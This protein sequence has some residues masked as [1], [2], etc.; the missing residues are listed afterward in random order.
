MKFTWPESSCAELRGVDRETAVRILHGLTRCGETEVA[1][2]HR[3]FLANR[4]WGICPPLIRSAGP[5]FVP[6]DAHLNMFVG[7]P[8]DSALDNEFEPCAIVQTHRPVDEGFNKLP[9]F[10]GFSRR[11]KHFLAADKQALA[12]NIRTQSEWRFNPPALDWQPQ[13]EIQVNPSIGGVSHR[14]LPHHPAYS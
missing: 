7:V 8:H 5:E 10:K 9:P 11:K 12:N 14:L 4:R 3:Y 13:V 1:V 2:S 6:Y